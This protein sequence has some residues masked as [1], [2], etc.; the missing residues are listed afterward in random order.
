MTS[1]DAVVDGSDHARALGGSQPAAYPP[2]AE[3][4]HVTDYSLI[5]GATAHGEID[6]LGKNGEAMKDETIIAFGKCVGPKLMDI[7][8]SCI[9]HKMACQVRVHSLDLKA[10]ADLD[11]HAKQGKIAIMLHWCTVC[12]TAPA[13]LHAPRLPSDSMKALKDEPA[14][15]RGVSKFI[16][17]LHKHYCWNDGACVD[18]GALLSAT[19]QLLSD[20]GSLALKAAAQLGMA[21]KT[22]SKS[23]SPRDATVEAA[24][25][26]YAPIEAKFR[27][28]LICANVFVN[29][30]IPELKYN[31]DSPSPPSA[32]GESPVPANVLVAPANGSQPH[33]VCSDPTA[34]KRKIAT[35]TKRDAHLTETRTAKETPNDIDTVF[36]SPDVTRLAEPWLL[37]LANYIRMWL[38]IQFSEFSGGVQVTML[39]NAPYMLQA[40][41][42]APKGV[43]FKA[44]QFRLSPFGTNGCMRLVGSDDADWFPA[45]AVLSPSLPTHAIFEVR[46]S[47]NKRESTPIQ[48]VVLRSP[49][50]DLRSSS[51]DD[52]AFWAVARVARDGPAHTMRAASET[53]EIPPPKSRLKLPHASKW[54]VTAP[55]IENVRTL[56]HGDLLSLPF[57][58]GLATNDSDSPDHVPLES[59]NQ[60]VKCEVEETPFCD[61][62]DEYVALPVA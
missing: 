27:S 13:P 56:K 32:N 61:A 54:Y 37:L 24:T 43:T 12:S 62:D 39:N 1:N 19:A 29:R 46:G 34:K 22:G 21:M 18:D 25:K 59:A 60:H 26:D 58:D 28:A 40:R 49:F 31:D 7:L 55:Y 45:N 50:Y 33:G 41:I 17:E 44:G 8:F 30:P 11:K 52:A 23:P 48:K 42:N 3:V 6:M 20:A 4:A 9:S 47:K 36:P 10:V 51:C 14:L 15:I 57:D 5:S 16:S 53:F 38:H 2:F 35:V